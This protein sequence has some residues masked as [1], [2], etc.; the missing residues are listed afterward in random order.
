M[1]SARHDRAETR[2]EGDSPYSGDDPARP[3][4]SRLPMVGVLGAR[5]EPED[6]TGANEPDLHEPEA[7]SRLA[8]RIG[9]IEPGDRP[10][11][12]PDTDAIPFGVDELVIHCGGY[13]TS[14]RTWDPR[15]QAAT[16]AEALATDAA[17][18]APVVAYDYDLAGSYWSARSVVETYGRELAAWID[19]YLDHSP[20]TDV[21][22]L[23][24]S[25]GGQVVVHCLDAL[26]ETVTSAGILVAGVAAD[27][28]T[29]GG[30]WYDAIASSCEQFNNYYKT[31]DRVALSWA[32]VE[33]AAPL[34]RNPADGTPPPN[35]T[36]HDVTDDV[37]L[38]V[39]AFKPRYGCMDVVADQWDRTTDDRTATLA[40]DELGVEVEPTA[41]QK[42]TADAGSQRVA[43]EASAQ[44]TAA[45]DQEATAETG[46]QG[47]ATDAEER[48]L[49]GRVADWIQRRIGVTLVGR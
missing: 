13:G 18:D 32:V 22:L 26:E 21:R 1:T 17:V 30:R 12:D 27:E 16:M 20:E 8:D 19:T 23:G 4:G 44:E 5:P 48:G 47:A 43:P 38:H 14:S 25:L 46:A 6:T 10:G 2:S 24:H 11:E 35:Y 29:R 39:S 3:F 49:L 9:T 15:S 34:G 28:V 45:G 31:D 36:D 40:D 42:A 33:L 37:A 41:A 7:T